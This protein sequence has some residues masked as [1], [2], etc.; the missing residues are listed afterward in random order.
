MMSFLLLVLTAAVAHA[1]QPLQGYHEAAGIPLAARIQ[2]EE[3]AVANSRIIGG[4]QVNAGAHPYL[5]GLIISLV[6]GR[7]SICGSSMLSNTKAVTAAHCWWDGR[8]Q[9]RQFTV[10]Y[11]SDRL[12]S[13]GT[14]VVTSNVELHEGFNPVTYSNDI[15]MITHPAVQ[16]TEYIG[17]VQLPTGT[18][19]YVDTW[20]VAVGYGRSSKDL[21]VSEAM[22]KRQVTLHVISNANCRLTW[23]ANLVLNGVLC[24][25]SVSGMSVCAGDAGGPL[26]AGSGTARTLIGIVSF[27]ADAGCS[28]GFPAAHTR[29][30]HYV[31][32]INARID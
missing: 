16:Y 11:G 8:T 18:S 21:M 28:L 10:V 25:S 15:A 7:S 22:D 14:R 5:G 3:Q 31:T 32:W 29:V 26:V 23:G 1:L 9:A 2:A 6:D 4:I 24:T 17:P 13:G 27:G 20:A 19:Q 30:T 12:F